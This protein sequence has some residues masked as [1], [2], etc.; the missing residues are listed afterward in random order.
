MMSN[1]FGGGRH[2][3]RAT[4]VATPLASN[5]LGQPQGGSAE[6]CDASQLY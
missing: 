1:G 2:V 6:E 5:L 4:V 3:F